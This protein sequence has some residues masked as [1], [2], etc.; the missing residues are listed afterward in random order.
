MNSLTSAEEK[1]EVKKAARLLN[2]PPIVFSFS[3]SIARVRF[4][5]VTKK[6]MSETCVT[7][8][9]ADGDLPY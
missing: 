8:Y 1:H 9:V 5:Y 2:Q 6:A 7:S 4:L 3:Y